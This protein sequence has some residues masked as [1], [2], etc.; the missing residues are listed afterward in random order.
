M[1]LG[2]QKTGEQLARESYKASIAAEGLCVEGPGWHMGCV[3]GSTSSSVVWE[4]KSLL[5]F[6]ALELPVCPP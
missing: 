5:D 4:E 1:V 2:G 3:E 6:R